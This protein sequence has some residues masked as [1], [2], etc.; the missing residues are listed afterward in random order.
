M[1]Q[2]LQFIRPYDV[3]DPD[4]LI[5]LGDAYDTAIASLHDGGQPTIVRETMAI[6][7]F[8]LASKGER[9]RDRLC[10]A[11]LGALGSRI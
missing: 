10:R 1:G 3:F 8:E 7:M 5:I 2:I 6:R 4:T 9:D 11:A